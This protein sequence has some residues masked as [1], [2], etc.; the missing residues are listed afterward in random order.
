MVMSQKN[1]ENMDFLNK[2]GYG[3]SINGNDERDTQ[4]DHPEDNEWNIPHEIRDDNSNG[5]ATTQNTKPNYTS[6]PNSI[7]VTI[8]DKQTPIVI[9]YGPPAC[10][11]TMTLVRLARFLK[12]QGYQIIPDNNFRESED[13]KY[14]QLCKDFDNIIASNEAASSTDRIS[15]MLVKVLKDGHPICQILEAPGEHYYKPGEK[16]KDYPPY[17]YRIINQNNRKVWAIII[18]PD[19]KN[20]VDKRGYVDN[21]KYL[22]QKVGHRNNGFVFVYNKID[23]S[24]A[25]RIS[26][27]IKEVSDQFTGIFVPFKNQ[28][29][30]TKLWRS[31]LCDFVTFQT[32]NYSQAMDGTLTYTP[33]NDQF[34]QR[35]WNS[36]LKQLRG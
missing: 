36:I 18:E 2:N 4:L 30:I 14:H 19:W 21:V 8:S 6:D 27:A 7:T 24:Q 1:E 26:D 29:P 5:D 3:I 23:K 32:G 17:I 13:P 22:K 15:F 9:L 16:D 20:E 35:L 25:W 28:N 10:G 34:P 11:K 31:Y 12:D 33:S